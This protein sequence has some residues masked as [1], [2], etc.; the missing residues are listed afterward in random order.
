MNKNMDKN[1]I[2]P[3]PEG[4]KSRIYTNYQAASGETSR[5]TA[6]STLCGFAASRLA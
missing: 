3:I 4:G 5:I 2:M 1:K 6:E